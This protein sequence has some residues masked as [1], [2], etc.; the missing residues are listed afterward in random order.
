MTVYSSMNDLLKDAK[1]TPI[2]HPVADLPLNQ[3]FWAIVERNMTRGEIR[4]AFLG[5]KEAKGKRELAYIPQDAAFAGWQ[6][7]LMTMDRMKKQ[8]AMQAQAMKQQQDQQA[9]EAKHAEGEHSRE[10][11]A[12]DLAMKEAQARHAQAAVTGGDS[13]K[14]VAKSVGAASKP[15][16]IGGTPVANPINTLGKDVK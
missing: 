15:L 11:E 13:L 3:A 5:D 14:D 12:H 16:E 9:L 2:D 1:K 10:Q 8:D 4:E 6:Q 7:L